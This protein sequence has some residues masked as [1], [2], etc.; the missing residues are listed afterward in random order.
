[1]IGQRYRK[2]IAVIMIRERM[3]A[4]DDPINIVSERVEQET[5][6]LSMPLKTS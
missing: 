2:G 4:N 1:M 6:A 3:S 5:D